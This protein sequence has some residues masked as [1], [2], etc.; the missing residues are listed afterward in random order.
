MIN[1]NGD[2]LRNLKRTPRKKGLA[3][4]PLTIVFSLVKPSESI[5]T[6]EVLGADL[7]GLIERFKEYGEELGLQ[8]VFL[9]MFIKP[10]AQAGIAE[11]EWEGS[12]EC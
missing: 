7:F 4:F 10:F 8:V 5:G 9:R 11:G 3:D 2:L 6:L 12:W 1:R